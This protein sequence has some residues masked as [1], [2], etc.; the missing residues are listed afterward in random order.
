MAHCNTILQ[1]MLKLNGSSDQSV[2]GAKQLG[3]EPGGPAAPPQPHHPAGEDEE[4][5]YSRSCNRLP[6][7]GLINYKVEFRKSF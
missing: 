3:E 2:P 6:P 4:A 5:E 1:Q 7:A